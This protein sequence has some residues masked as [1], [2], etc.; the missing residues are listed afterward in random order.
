M[1]PPP[2]PKPPLREVLGELRPFLVI[3]AGQM[4]SA[5]GSGLTGFAVPVAVYQRT[6]SAEQL[7]LL[8]LAWIVPSLLLSPIAGTLVDRWDRRRVLVAADTGEAVLTLTLAALVLNGHFEMWYLLATTVA[9]SLIAAFQEPAFAASLSVLV[10]PRHYARAVGLMQLLAPV[11]MVVAPL[12]AGALLATLGLGGIIAVDGV[13]YLAAIAALLCVRIPSP[14]HAPAEPG[15]GGGWLAAL[16]GF[17]RE[18]AMG[19][20]FLR[21]HR[22]LFGLVVLFAL[23]NFWGGFVNPL[24]TPMLLAFARPAQLATVQAVA[25]FGA[26]LGGVAVGVWGGPRRRVAGMVATLAAGGAC[27]VAMGLGPSLPL[28]GG[29]VFVWALTSPVLGASS[30]AVWMSKTP[31][32]LLGRVFAVRRVISLGALPLAVLVA[33]PLAQRVFEPMLAPGGRLAASV[34]AAIGVGPGRGIALIFILVGTL[35]LLTALGGWLVPAIRTVERDVP[36]AAP[37][38]AA[39]VPRPEAEAEPEP[40][41]AAAPA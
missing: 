8:M 24:L 11:S 37:S 19:Y 13:T 12:L 10:P 39:H 36:D 32:A 17:G 22:G 31:Q 27:T 26:V 14:A 25:G 18:T 2:Q 38:A 1:N 16:R 29:A 34:G 21:S 5:L 35:T 20:R 33:G 7:A 6:G 30:A 3:W 15:G 9:A 23:G 28:V 40:A 4:V 41:G